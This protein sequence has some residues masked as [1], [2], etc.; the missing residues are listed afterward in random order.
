MFTDPAVL[1]VLP[2]LSGA[3]C[4]SEGG[5]PLGLQ[6]LSGAFQEDTLYTVAACLEKQAGFAG[7]PPRH[8]AMIN[9]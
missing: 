3:A 2:G 7:Q 8:A 4:F 6:V 5:L 9:Q 1:V